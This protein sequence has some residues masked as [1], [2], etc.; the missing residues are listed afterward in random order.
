VGR[1]YRRRRFVRVNRVRLREIGRMVDVRPSW[2]A[3]EIGGGRRR[4]LVV[5]GCGDGWRG[6]LGERG[7]GSICGRGENEEK[8]KTK[9]HQMSFQIFFFK[10]CFFFFLLKGWLTQVGLT[11]PFCGRNAHIM[12]LNSITPMGTEFKYQYAHTWFRQ[13]DKFIHYVN[14]VGAFQNHYKCFT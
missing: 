10:C 12:L 2:W 14:Q 1:T 6:S 7:G 5:A 13:M 11:S 8:P 3:A 4:C 9:R